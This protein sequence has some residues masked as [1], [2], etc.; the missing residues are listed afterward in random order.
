MI[1]RDSDALVKALV[2]DLE[3]VRPLLSL[4]AAVV[5]TVG[6]GAASLAAFAALTDRTLLR[7]DL[8]E[9]ASAF[10]PFSAVA[11]GLALL[12]SGALVFALVVREPGRDARGAAVL[13]AFAALLGPAALLAACLVGDTPP[14]P[15]R[16]A[17]L[18]C[19][20][21]C[22]A[23][24]A[25]PAA[26]ALGLA[27]CGAVQRPVVTAA[28]IGA[29]AAALGAAAVHLGCPDDGIRHVLV[30]HALAPSV[31]A[32]VALPAALLL[33]RWRR[34]GLSPSR[35]PAVARAPH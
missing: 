3:P 34:C 26:V 9:R 15:P 27:A 18:G 23:V 21:G 17:D 32:L 1:P 7:A 12:A 30:S 35:A 10:A 28:L 6:A 14:E 33:A 19:L 20:L 4:R 22:L 16:A 13:A 24:G 11:V 2:R 29:G 5:Y 8:V 31:G 25:L